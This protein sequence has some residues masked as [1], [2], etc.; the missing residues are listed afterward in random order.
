MSTDDA[1]WTFGSVLPTVENAS[2]IVPV[3]IW[4]T[5]D[6]PMTTK[7]TQTTELECVL[8]SE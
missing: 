5:I 4:T 1:M 3:T 2:I 8:E 7:G 6:A